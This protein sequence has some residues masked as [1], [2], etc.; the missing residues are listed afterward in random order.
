MG[1]GD[2]GLRLGAPRPVV[3]LAQ[4]ARGFTDRLIVARRIL[5]EH[6]DIVRIDSLG[7]SSRCLGVGPETPKKL[8]HYRPSPSPTGRLRQRLR[9]FPGSKGIDTFNCTKLAMMAWAASS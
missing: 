6:R 8:S 1:N 7:P 3:T 9:L 2:E 4:L 5:Q